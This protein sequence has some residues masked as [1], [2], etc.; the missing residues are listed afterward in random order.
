MSD[1]KGMGAIA[2][3]NLGLTK[4]YTKKIIEFLTP[5]VLVKGG[6]YTVD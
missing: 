5:D 1:L 6:D 2:L 4:E 3:G